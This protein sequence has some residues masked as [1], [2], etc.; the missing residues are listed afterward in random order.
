MSMSTSLAVYFAERNKGYFHNLYMTFTDNPHFITLK[1]ND[2]IYQKLAKAA[3]TD[4]G[5]NTDLNKAFDLVL[6][7]GIDNKI[8]NDEMPKAIIVISDMEIDWISR[9]DHIN[10]DFVE[11]QRKKFAKYGYN[12]PKLVLWNVESRHN[13]FLGNSPDLIHV[14]GGSPSSFREL[15]GALNDKTGWDIM[16]ETLNNPMYDCIWIGKN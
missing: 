5:Y 9:R 16:I 1:E 12:L 4:W 2:D 14:S 10:D 8:S 7:T 11:I 13:T 6:R 15:T 3:G